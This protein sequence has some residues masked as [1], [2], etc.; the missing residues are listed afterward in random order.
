MERAELESLL[1]AKLSPLHHKINRFEERQEKIVDILQTQAEQKANISH[2]LV[3]LERVE[4]TLIREHE[5][6]FKRL[7]AIEGSNVEQ[8]KQDN[9]REHK[10]LSKRIGVVEKGSGDKI[11]DVLKMFLVALIAAVIG[12]YSRS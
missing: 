11:W 9:I 1:D 10:E 5:D 3:G 6:I 8:A 7:R 2:I 4:G 12:R